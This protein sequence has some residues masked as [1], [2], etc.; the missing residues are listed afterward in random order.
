MTNNLLTKDVLPC[1]VQ[2]G[3]AGARRLFPD[4]PDRQEAEARLAMVRDH[5]KA[6]LQALPAALKFSEHHFCCGI[7]S[8]AIGADTLFTQ[9]CQSLAIPQRI[10]FPQHRDDFFNARDSQGSPD[11]DDHGRETALKLLGSP[12]I[13][14]ERLVSD[15]NDRHERFS[16][17][18]CELAMV[19]DVLICLF[20][21]DSGG[22]PG[23][24]HELLK[25]AQ[26]QGKPTLEIRVSWNDGKPVFQDYWHMPQKH[27]LPQLPDEIAPLPLRLA[28]STPGAA[29]LPSVEDFCGVV[30]KHVSDLARKY[31]QYFSYAA[32]AILVTHVFATFCATVVL[33]SHG[34]PGSH[35]SPDSDGGTTNQ[36]SP[37]TIRL[38]AGELVFLSVG[39]TVHV[40]LH[41]KRVSAIWALNRLLAEINRSVRSL[42][43]IHL[44][45]DYLLGLQLPSKLVPLLR[46]L[47]ILHLRGTKRAPG[48]DWEAMRDAYLNNRLTDSNP[49]KGQIVYYSKR[50]QDE[51][52]WLHF[53]HA[54][55]YVCSA[56]AFIAT[57]FELLF[58]GRYFPSTY[59]GSAAIL[60]PVLAVAALSWA[61]AKDYEARVHTYRE[62]VEFLKNQVA[63]I[64]S[65]VSR[66]E[67]SRLIKETETH[68]LRETADWYS[69]R[70]HTHGPS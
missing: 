33:A 28:S 11:F 17:C 62:M 59:L 16:D 10:F 55:F 14:E 31:S 1:V 29:V 38:L 8:L 51:K 50:C 27:D 41:K 42:G 56:A 4:Q 13:I 15:S 69:R 57:L 52:R 30:K 40:L 63:R 64:Q 47:N 6:K 58:P 48:Q 24:T 70:T 5:L 20:H 21:S 25:L 43:L 61:A 26:A 60:L 22:E 36:G 44:P 7:S 46:T 66:R 18:N 37:W 49:Q 67:N 54:G 9:V 2:V 34:S 23:G 35:G 12:H 65:A 39:F 53:A 3:F 32:L 68:L 19:S 45:L